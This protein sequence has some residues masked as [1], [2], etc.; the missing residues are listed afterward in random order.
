MG[1][2]PSALVSWKLHLASSPTC[3]FTCIPITNACRTGFVSTAWFA[4]NSLNHFLYFF[5]QIFVLKISNPLINLYF[6]DI[7]VTITTWWIARLWEYLKREEYIRFYHVSPAAL[8]SLWPLNYFCHHFA[9]C[10]LAA[11]L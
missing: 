2:Y 6:F 10:H 11:P 1:F 4:S 9:T 7:R 5:L 3:I 8:P